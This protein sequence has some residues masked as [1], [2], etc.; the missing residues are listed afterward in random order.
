MSLVGWLV[1]V[2][3]ALATQNAQAQAPLIEDLGGAEGFGTE[4]L[5]PNDD[6]SSTEIDLTPAFPGGLEFFGRRYTSVYVNTNGNITFDG[7]LSQFTPDSFPVAD[8][9]MIAPYWGDVDIRGSACSG[10]GGSDGCE[11]PA[12]NGVWWHLEPGRLVVTWDEV[13]FFD[14]ND[15]KRMS[16]QL[17][18]STARHCG[19]PGDFDVE[20]RYNRCEWEVGEASG[21]ENGNGICDSDEGPVDVCTPAQV[22]F[23]A[24]NLTDFVSVEGSRMN[25]IRN[26]MCGESNVGTRGVWRFQIRRG[27]ISCPDAGEQCDTGMVGACQIGR[28]ACV[29]AGTECQAVVTPTDE[30]CNGAD[31]DCDGVTDEGDLCAGGLVCDRGTCIDA[32][33]D[34]SCPD[35]EICS[36]DGFCVDP[37][38]A[39]ADC[40]EGERCMG[41][42]CV[43][44]CEGVACPAGQTC[45][46]GR[47]RDLCELITCDSCQVCADGACE[48]H[49]I[50]RGCPTGMACEETGQCVEEDCLGVRCGPGRTCREGRC[51]DTCAGVQCPTGETCH[52]GECVSDRILDVDAG[53]PQ[54]DAG[55]GGGPD[56]GVSADGGSVGPTDRG[57]CGCRVATERPEGSPLTLALVALGLMGV[58]VGRRRQRSGSKTQRRVR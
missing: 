6:G 57:G 3:C 10:S 23:D 13:G 2:L 51:A 50:V 39:E 4:C 14:C 11:D 47:C 19:V 45:R 15:D 52:M 48:L 49:C 58:F 36:E 9:P 38:C 42:E 46:L 41:G 53:S 17:I 32:C 30:S 5:S 40:E 43:S 25:G 34:D 21:D 26:Q 20:F 33:F 31:D 37:A 56:G 16:F 12:F 22:G 55:G 54:V 18:L 8:R 44:A 27:E 28:T 1:G 29:G 24:G 35:P 7:P